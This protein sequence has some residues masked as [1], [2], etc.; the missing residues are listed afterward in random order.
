MKRLDTQ[1]TELAHVD[2]LSCKEKFRSMKLSHFAINFTGFRPPPILG[3]VP[4]LN[5]YTSLLSFEDKR[6]TDEREFSVRLHGVGI[7]THCGGA[8][9]VGV[10]S[11]STGS[12][13][14]L[15]TKTCPGN[16]IKSPKR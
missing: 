16:H 4:I 2:S 8:S 7:S 14:R 6:E 11:G 15:S 5:Q 13:F 9:I 3:G 10:A 1:G 12:Q